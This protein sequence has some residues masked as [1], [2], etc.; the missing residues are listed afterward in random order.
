MEGGPRKQCCRTLF[1]VAVLFRALWAGYATSLNS[2]CRTE[3]CL[4]KR[5][6]NLGKTLPFV[7]QLTQIMQAAS[8]KAW[9]CGIRHTVGNQFVSTSR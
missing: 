4:H 5:I 6:Q 9:L 7:I 3:C 2:I 1:A 8:S